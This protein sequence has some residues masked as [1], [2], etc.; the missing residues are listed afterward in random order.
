MQSFRVSEFGPD[1]LYLEE[2]DFLDKFNRQKTRG[3]RYNIVLIPEKYKEDFIN[4]GYDKAISGTT[5]V[6]TVQ[7]AKFL[8]Y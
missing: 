6:G 8:Y 3:Y 4:D 7:K 1:I 2:D 5:H